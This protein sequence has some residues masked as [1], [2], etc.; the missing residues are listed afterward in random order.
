MT[1]RVGEGGNDDEIHLLQQNDRQRCRVPV[2]LDKVRFSHPDFFQKYA[3]LTYIL[4]E[5]LNVL[6]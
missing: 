1:D 2:R 3:L 6:L 4:L 5:I